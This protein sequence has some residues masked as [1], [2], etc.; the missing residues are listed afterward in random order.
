MK[1]S[2]DSI[3]SI[4][5]EYPSL[6][7]KQRLLQYELTHPVQ[8]T[9]EE[10]L[11]AKAYPQ[12]QCDVSTK[13]SYGSNNRNLMLAL[14][15]QKDTRTINQAV[16]DEI[17]EELQLVTKQIK[18]L[19]FYMNLLPKEHYLILTLI[20]TERKSWGEIEMMTG[21]SRRTVIRRKTE[22][23]ERLAEMYNYA[24]QFRQE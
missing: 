20:Y 17:L 18:R 8:I 5:K 6:K 23:V 21:L 15:Y 2:S 4:L 1:Y 12:K 16:I 19:E 11:G 24:E 22:A 14:N 10:L 3:I 7:E 13:G 9:E